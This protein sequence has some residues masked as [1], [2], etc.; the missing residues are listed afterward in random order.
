MSCWLP[1]LPQTLDQITDAFGISDIRRPERLQ[2]VRQTGFVWTAREGVVCLATNRR[3][4]DTARDNPGVVAIIVPPSLAARE[5]A[6]ERAV[7]VCD[8]ADQLYHHL[9]RLQPEDTPVDRIELDPGASIDPSA[10]LR[11]D[12]CV[13]AGARIGARVVING[14]ATIGRDVRVDAGAILGCEGL[15]AKRVLGV[16]QHM[17]HF[18]G[19]EIG[20]GAFIHAGAVIVRSAIRGECTRIGARAHIGILSNIGHDAQVGEEATISSNV[21]LAGRAIIG[22]RVWIGASATVSN[23]VQIGAD[24]EVR[25]G[26]VVVQDVPVGGDV[27]GNFALAHGRNMKRFLKDSRNEP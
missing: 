24:A 5:D 18:G 6:A 16:R 4:L 17:P 20:E 14:P 11:G 10:V 13:G 15:Y 12:V 22:P 19:V 1:N 25:L 21:V 2:A 9:H 7:I 3:Y 23:M 26:A 27:S 8:K